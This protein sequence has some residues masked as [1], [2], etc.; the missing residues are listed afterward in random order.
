MRTCALRR[1]PPPLSYSNL[2]DFFWFWLQKMIILIIWPPLG[3]PLCTLSWSTMTQASGM[4]IMLTS[5][6]PV[7]P[8][9]T[10]S[11]MSSRWLETQ[12]RF[13]FY[14]CSNFFFYKLVFFHL[15]RHKN[16]FIFFKYIP[17]L[18]LG[19]IRFKQVYSCIY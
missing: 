15:K 7:L 4:W 18:R 9:S 11:V 5:S 2:H 10:N 14:C 6:Y 16:T 12:V 8:A 19:G 1:T 3:V 17:S 13:F